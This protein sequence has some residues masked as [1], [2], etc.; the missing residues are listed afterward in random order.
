LKALKEI[1]DIEN[2]TSNKKKDNMHKLLE[3]LEK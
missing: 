1:E 2:G 3:D